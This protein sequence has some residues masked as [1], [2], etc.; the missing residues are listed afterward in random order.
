MNHSLRHAVIRCKWL[1]KIINGCFNFIHRKRFN[2]IIRERKML[3]L[4]DYDKLVVSIPYSPSELVID[5][6]LYRIAYWLKSYA[7][8]DVNK[9][10]D[11]SIEHGV[12]FGNLVRE[13]DRLYPVKS[14]ITFG[15]RRIKHLEYGGINKNIIA[16][17]PYIHYAQSLLSYQEKSDLK[18]KLGRTLLVFPSHGII[19]VTATF[20]NDEFIEEIE[21]VRKDFDT[22]LISL[23]WTDVLKPDLVASYEALGYKIVTS[24][25]RFD[26]NFLSRQKSFI[27]LAD[28]TMSNNLG[29][30][31]GYCIHL[32]K[33]H[34]IFQQRVFYDAKD[35]KTQKHLSDASNQDNNLTYE[36]EL[37]EI[38]EAINQ[39]EIDITE[40]QREIVEE[41]WGESYIRTPEE[42]RNLLRYSK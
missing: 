20:N 8:L 36:W 15:N 11:A 26:L 6:N 31:V 39:Y 2:R 22:V 21:R 7:G 35:Q 17:G 5:N 24:G 37:K 27:E 25:H 38:C 29:T 34:Y 13:D 28:Y 42:L 12:F 19:G 3:S 18:A 4:F 14:M 32:N 41:Y 9:S 10:L 1:L 40:K 23:Y 16:V 33:P 30:H